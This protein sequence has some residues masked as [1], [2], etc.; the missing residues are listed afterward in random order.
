MPA[1]A[2]LAAIGLSIYAIAQSSR[3]WLTALYLIGVMAAAVGFGAVI[4]FAFSTPQMSG[5]LAAMLMPWAGIV[6]SI[7]R[8]RHYSKTKTAVR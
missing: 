4:G 5:H 2:M 8:I 3:K 1:L 6:A 7:E